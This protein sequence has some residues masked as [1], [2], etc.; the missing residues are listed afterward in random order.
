MSTNVG[1][2]VD[3]ASVNGTSGNLALQIQNW[4]AAVA[5][6]KAWLDTMPDA[7]LEIDPF[8]YTAEEV[9]LL[10]SA[11]NDMNTLAEVYR[12]LTDH[13]PASDMSVFVKRLAGV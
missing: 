12:G 3:K 13:T 9:A 2:P 8:S 1:L 11:T 4:S 7:D 10:K 6:F 5:R